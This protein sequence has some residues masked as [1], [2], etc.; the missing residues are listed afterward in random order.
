MNNEISE[1]PKIRN[2]EEMKR[3]QSAI[4]YATNLLFSYGEKT[5]IDD[6]S[7]SLAQGEHIGIIGESGCGKSTLLRLIA[8]LMPADSGTLEVNGESTPEKIRKQISMVFQEPKLMPLTIREN[9][10]LGR[11]IANE[12]LQKILE[13][14]KLFDWINTLP[15]GIDTYIGNKADELSGGQAQRIAIARAM[16]KDSPIILLDEPTSSLDKETAREVIEAIHELTKE[17]TVI[18]VTHQPELLAGFDSNRIN[19]SK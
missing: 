10:T 14:T 5:V 12:K 9:I 3:K 7:F 13:A 11:E 6:I 1:L 18:A 2:Q 16:A 4:I 17:K 19:V 15:E 8:G